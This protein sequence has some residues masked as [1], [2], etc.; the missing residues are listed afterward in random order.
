M[1][2][3]YH[4]LEFFRVQFGDTVLA[5]NPPKKTSNHK[6]ARFGA[7]IV[8]SSV[9]HEDFLGGSL[10]DSGDKEPFLITGPGEYEVQEIFIR[11]YPSKTHYGGDERINT[12]YVATLEGMNLVFLGALDEK[13]LPQA[14]AEAIDVVDILFVPIGGE[15]VL[16]AVEA[17]K[18]GVKL[19]ASVI[20][21]MHYDDKALKTFLKEE[22]E[23]KVKPQE[24]LTLKPR[25]VSGREGDILVLKES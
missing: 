10:L 19:E 4:G 25:D 18:L 22:G 23:E 11:G 24:K 12:I 2:I 21:P 7:D 20:I 17:H 13:E 8:M 6:S 9:R 16:N 14:A 3:T 1:V 5:F 15:G